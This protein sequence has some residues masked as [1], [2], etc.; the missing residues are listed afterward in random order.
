MKYWAF[1]KINILKIIEIKKSEVN[2]F[3]ENVTV[4]YVVLTSS[5]TLIF[6]LLQRIVAGK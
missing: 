4:R 1:L 3:L 5:L 6:D 2:D